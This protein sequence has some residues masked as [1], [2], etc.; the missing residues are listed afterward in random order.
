MLLTLQLALLSRSAALG[1]SRTSS[2]TELISAKLGSVTVY[3]LSPGVYMIR[4]SMGAPAPKKLFIEILSPIRGKKR[5]QRVN[6]CV[7]VSHPF[8]NVEYLRSLESLNG[9]HCIA[10][11]PATLKDNQHP[12]SWRMTR[13]FAGRSSRLGL[14]PT[15]SGRALDVT[16]FSVQKTKLKFYA[17]QLSE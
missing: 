10:L 12:K 15:G 7:K 6:I 2:D 4:G 9:L 3:R 8:R 17:A 13:H 1:P 11:Q 14:Q 16:H 5:Q